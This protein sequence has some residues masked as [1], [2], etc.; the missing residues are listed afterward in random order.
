[1]FK[2]TSWFSSLCLLLIFFST[3]TTEWTQLQGTA[4]FA[5]CLLA[6]F[7][8]IEFK[9]LDLTSKIIAALAFMLTATLLAMGKVSMD[10][11]GAMCAS[12]SFFAFFL[13]ALSLLKEAA[14]TS[15]SVN[16]T[17]QALL[18]QQAVKRYA[19]LT[20]AS[21][22]IGI[23]MSMGAINLLGTMIHRSL[24]GNKT[25][26]DPRINSARQRRMMQATIRG[27]CSIPLWAPTTVTITLLVTTIPNLAWWDI[28]PYGLYL[29][30]IILLFGV[31]LDYIQAPTYLRHLVPSM[32]NKLADLKVCYPI[33]LVVLGLVVVSAALMLTSPLRAISA[34]LMS[35]PIVSLIWIIAQ[36]RRQGDIFTALTLT[37]QRFTQDIFFKLSLQRNEIV[38]FA[39]SVLIGRL[40]LAVL[41]VDW[42]A[43]QLAYLNITP[44][45][46]LILASWFIFIGSMLYINTMISVTLVAG[47]LAQLPDLQTMP[48]TIALVMMVTWTAVIGSAPSA[49]SVRIAAKTVEVSP[50]QLGIKW[51]GL[52]SILVLVILDCYLLLFM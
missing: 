43:Q 52:Y 24:Q 48:V 33:L 31:L 10:D 30:A 17:G 42:V 21:H 22:L 34:V 4:I 14:L 15:Q 29:T 50:L 40:L 23:L 44:A 39:S 13:I 26:I 18:Q 51:N 8:C 47:A 3:L 41:D 35:A 45:V 38:F 36:Y 46:L 6:L 32:T 12:V 16:L 37:K 1:M 49:T 9:A 28:M 5:A 19:L 25:T 11:L 7:T 27:F 20:F 2:H